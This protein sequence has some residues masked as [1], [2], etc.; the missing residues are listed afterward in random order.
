[1]N[2]REMLQVFREVFPGSLVLAKDDVPLPEEAGQPLYCKY[3]GQLRV[4]DDPVCQHHLE[5]FDQWCWERCETE[6]TIKR[7]KP[8]LSAVYQQ[9]KDSIPKKA[10]SRSVSGAF[11]SLWGG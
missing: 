9:R 6:W 5:S 7:L 1:M 11:R 2:A 8:A 4:V 10:P 3:H